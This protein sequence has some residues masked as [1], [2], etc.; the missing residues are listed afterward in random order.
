MKQIRNEHDGLKREN[1]SLKAK[2]L[3]NGQEIR[4][5]YEGKEVEGKRQV[6]R[7]SEDLAAVS[8]ELREEKRSGARWQSELQNLK[9]ELRRYEELLEQAKRK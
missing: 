6:Q 9:T 1:T 2:L 3:E 8:A 4:R 7:L 5:S